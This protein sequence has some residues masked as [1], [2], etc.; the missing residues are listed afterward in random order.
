MDSFEAEELGNY[1]SLSS[2]AVCAFLLGIAS[3]VALLA[4]LMVAIPIAGVV[5][6]LFALARIS[7]SAGALSGRGLALAGLA[8]AIACAV[9]SPLRIQVRDKLYSGQADEAGRQWLT[10]LSRGEI[11]SSLNQITGNAK[12]GLM[13]PP[14]HD[15]QSPKYVTETAVTALGNDVL[16][17]KLREEAQHGELKFVTKSLACDASG[18]TPR[19]AATYQ[20]TEPDDSLT[21][22][23]VLLRS[24]AD[25]TW[26]IDS[27]H[28]EG[29]S[30]HD[31]SHAHPHPHPH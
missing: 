27:W 13:G 28:L 23:V 14:S 21:M 24:S 3:L 25:G 26:L 2:L 9:A 11:D 30:A 1:R 4:P 17:A 15:G 5:V 31:H 29:E 19:A 22:S 8:L 16:V 7:N 10:A 20:T 18:A 6:A 12:G